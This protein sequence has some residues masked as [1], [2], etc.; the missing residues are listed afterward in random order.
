MGSLH[1]PPYRPPHAAERPEHLEQPPAVSPVDEI[2]AVGSPELTAPA[3]VDRAARDDGCLG[4]ESGLASGRSYS[5]A[6]CAAR[7]SRRRSPRRSTRAESKAIRVPDPVGRRPQPQVLGKEGA[8]LGD[9][10]TMPGVL[11]VGARQFASPR[12]HFAA[13]RPLRFYS[14]R[15]SGRVMGAEFAGRTRPSADS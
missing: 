15:L 9:L 13:V 5:M 2:P 10:Q 3:G 8:L 4:S 11:I 14:R 1:V 6:R 12:S 7:Y